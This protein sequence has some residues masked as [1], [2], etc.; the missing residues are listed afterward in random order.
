MKNPSFLASNKLPGP[1]EGSEIRCRFW[2]ADYKGSS[3]VCRKSE[4]TVF[5]RL[6]SR[7]ELPHPVDGLALLAYREMRLG[8]S[9]GIEQIRRQGGVLG[10]LRL[11]IDVRVTKQL[12]VRPRILSAV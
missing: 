8:Q 6:R 2:F 9:T 3:C 5:K 10:F 1:G 11:T 12:F 4:L 7:Y